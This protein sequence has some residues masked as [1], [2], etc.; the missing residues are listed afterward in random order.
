MNQILLRCLGHTSTIKSEIGNELLLTSKVKITSIIFL[1]ETNDIF[2]HILCSRSLMISEIEA[3]GISENSGAT[4]H[5]L[6]ELARGRRA[7]KLKGCRATR[8][9]SSRDGRDMHTSLCIR[10]IYFQSALE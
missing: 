7:E 10:S 5:E 9:V 2:V 6:G 1:V 8:P 4:A 3:E